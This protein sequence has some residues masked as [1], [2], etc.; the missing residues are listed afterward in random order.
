MKS[1]WKQC[2]AII[3][4]SFFFSLTS[5]VGSATQA[6]SNQPSSQPVAAA[7]QDTESAEAK[8]NRKQAYLR[9]MEAQR[10]LRTARPPRFN[11]LIVL[12]KEIIQL[13]P[14][15]ADPHADLA[16]IYFYLQQFG[17]TEHEA[18]EAIRL[19][20]DC[21][22]GH[23]WLGRLA[24]ITVRFEKEVKPAQID[25]A[26]RSYEEVGRI[27][28][29]NAEAWAF[30]ADLYQMKNDPLR[31][32]RAL[33]KLTAIGAPTETMFYR[34]VMNTD[35]AGE[36]AWY[37]LSQLYLAQGKHAQAIEAARRAFEGDP[38]SAVNARHLMNMLRL[39]SNGEEELQAYYRLLKRYNL[40][41]LQV[42]YSAALVRVGRYGEAITRLH[43]LQKE[44][45]LNAGLIELLA[46]AQ[47]R[48]GKRAEAVETLK[49]GIAR[50]E[51]SARQK[52]HLLLGE[53]YEELGRPADAIACY[54]GVFNE[55][56]T[57]SKLD[58]AST[59]R[60]ISVVTRLTR[61]YNR[62][63]S[64]KKAQAVFARAQQML[65]ENNPMMSSL[66]I[67]E[68]R[69]EG[70]YREALETTRAALLRYPNDRSLRL[71]EAML[72]G[73]LRNY[74]ESLVAL[75]A[76]RQE[77]TV[78]D[79]TLLTIMSN[80]QLQ[81]GQLKE[82]EDTIRQAI[83][84]DPNDMDLLIQLGSIQDRAGQRTE[85][86]KT[87]R[88]VLQR[89]PDNATALNNLGYYLAER[90]ARYS[91][92]L[93]LIEK[94][95]SIE[96]LNGSFLDSLGWVQHKLGRLQEARGHL[97]KAALYARR[98]AT[99]YEHLGDVLRDLGRLQEARRNWEA[100]LG[101]SVET[102]VIARLKDKIKAT[103]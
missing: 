17:S 57:K 22:N 5:W 89:E 99:V 92:A 42:G 70:K 90:N 94:A 11:D 54:E 96:P 100:A 41:L 73:D 102:T 85:A 23:K 7:S 67:D 69:E 39:S 71:T 30:L 68:L 26:I 6:S 79:T 63:G 87:L 1:T 15:A 95:V 65:G 83:S 77:Q 20:P 86:E 3:S 75:R 34:Q 13:D 53:T 56:T 72:L 29:T 40:P 64:K 2:I 52:L 33:E 46:V 19:D 88:A 78:G 61:T 9:Y 32:T 28:A 58:V 37:Q 81:S 35:L 97:E 74:S 45:P 18:R 36:Q 27:D 4:A 51:P 43:K 25:H 8:R 84:L 44:D 91:E 12:Y 24:M 62:Q 50:L 98:N 48:S 80:I 103:Q 66:L 93:P 49:Q 60:L 47:R 14:I 21:L 59:E 31:Q 55:L 82:A 38:D 16:E 76:L 10:I 101:Y